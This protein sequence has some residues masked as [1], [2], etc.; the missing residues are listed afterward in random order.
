MKYQKDKFEEIEEEKRV[1]REV[2]ELNN[3]Y[4]IENGEEPLP[5]PLELMPAAEI[6]SMVAG[7][8]TDATTLPPTMR[9]EVHQKIPEH[10]HIPVPTPAHPIKIMPNQFTEITYP[11]QYESEIR[12]HD[13]P[14]PPYYPSYTQSYRI[15]SNQPQNL[16]ERYPELQGKQKLISRTSGTAEKLD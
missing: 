13:L 1:K 16:E 9:N 7:Y 12:Y 5:I 6:Q 15:P 10:T 2:F 14:P 3:Q 8:A 4:R 11:P